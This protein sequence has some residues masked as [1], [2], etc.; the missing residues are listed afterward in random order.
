[1]SGLFDIPGARSSKEA[2][3]IIATKSRVKSASVVTTRGSSMIDRIQLIKQTVDIKLGKYKDAYSV[4][5]DRSELRRYLT[6]C[7]AN[8]ICALDTE[9]T[10]LDPMQDKIAGL[11]L[12]TPHNNG[13]YIPINHES[14]IT[15]LRLSNQLSE[16]VVAE[17]LE[18]LNT[19]RTK[20]IMHNAKFD[21]RV[22]K[23]QL[24]VTLKCYW[25]T[26]LASQL[27]NEN[28]PHGLKALH[29]KYVLN[30]N[31]DGYSFGK[32]FDGLVFTKVPIEVAYMYAARDPHITYE[33]Y[34]FQKPY[35]TKGTQE[36]IEQELEKVSEVFWDIEM[37]FLNVAI[38]MED[39]GIAFD[40][41]YQA[42]L[43][44][45]YGKIKEEKLQVFYNEL[46]KYQDKIDT[47]RLNNPVN[48]LD[49]PINISSPT[50]LAVLLY[51]IIGV[52]EI[53][54]KEPRGTGEKILT[55]IDLP[56]C[57]AIL[58]YRGVDKIINTYIEKLPDCINP[59]DG[60]IH[61]SFNQYGARTG[62]LSSD[63][64]NL[65]N[66]PSHNKDIR[67]LFVA[68]DG[69]VLMSSDYSQQEV[70]VFAEL[71]E[72]PV[73]I[74]ALTDGKDVYSMIAAVAFGT[75]YEDCRE[76]YPDGT[77]NKDGKARRTSA[78]SIVLGIL[79]G[80]GVDS[81]AEQ[82]GIS[83]NEAQ[84]IKDKV[85]KAFPNFATF[86]ESTLTMAET[87]GYVTTLWGR[88]R[89]LPEM[90][91]PDYQY[92]YMDGYGDFDPLDF[93]AT[94]SS[95][96]P[97]EKVQKYNRML[98]GATFGRKKK[99]FEKINAEGVHVIDNTKKIQDTTRECVNARVQGSAADLS[100]LAGIE[101]YNNQRLREL[102]FKLLIPVHDE[103]I[104]MAPRETAKECA[105]LFSKCMSDAARRLSMPIT[106]DVEISDR[107]YGESIREEDL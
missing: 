8:G 32:L 106:T 35:L 52:G 99:I 93:T 13:V 1:M 20:I 105:K 37:P 88:K 28:E 48:K 43:S 24:G 95:E 57:K 76:F 49:N 19:A 23:H 10:G 12:Y 16:D 69:C 87:K 26:M 41:D 6:A 72:D 85:I 40:M 42:E 96:V 61:C 33:L 22:C 25:D 38:E 91:L 66:I 84:S 36:C 78:K 100:K 92:E 53:S 9:T 60:K 21:I 55:Q 11:C 27:L 79:Y 2:D 104:G 90:M 14:Y 44:E 45:K 7:A 97:Y 98:R 75:T 101:I 46:A 17:E 56:I 65:Q 103:Y 59:R 62:R 86:E 71:S 74:Q 64:P 82:L 34:E 15:G 89:R 107:W 77:T 51:D 94:V 102:G 39:N 73:M 18:L 30:G 50:Q 47:Y 70:K 67:K 3:K 63:S 58:D 68:D 83:V 29:Q 80:R 4:I 81:I 5:T 31:D 54:R